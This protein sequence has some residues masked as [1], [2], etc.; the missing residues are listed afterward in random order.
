MHDEL[1]CL[2]FYFSLQIFF[3]V[4]LIELCQ[5]RS[6]CS[7]K[8]PSHNSLSL[9]ALEWVP[10]NFLRLGMDL[11]VNGEKDFSDKKAV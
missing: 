2:F 11:G 6:A 10:D 9:F 5:S 3:R 4:D 8:Q 7:K 1:E